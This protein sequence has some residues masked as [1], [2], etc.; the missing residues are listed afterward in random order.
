M[1][2]TDV[3]IAN[4]SMLEHSRGFA[5][6]AIILKGDKQIGM[7]DNQGTGGVTNV[8]I[9]SEKKWFNEQM[10][11][12]FY[13]L[14]WDISKSSKYS[15]EYTFAEHLIDIFEEGKLSEESLELGILV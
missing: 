15:L 10:H 5:Y 9:T 3:K 11:H 6:S 14:G 13:Q 8:H 4:V 1:T 12:H 2:L 7:L